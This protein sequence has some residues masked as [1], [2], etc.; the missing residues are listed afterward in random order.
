MTSTFPIFRYFSTLKVEVD[1]VKW[2]SKTNL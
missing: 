2:K 1:C